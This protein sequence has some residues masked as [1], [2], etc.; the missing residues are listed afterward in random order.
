M[1]YVIIA[2]VLP[3]EVAV[4]TLLMFRREIR[5]W[6]AKRRYRRDSIPHH[7]C[8]CC[9]RCGGC[10][11]QLITFLIS[12]K[13][14]QVCKDRKTCQKTQAYQQMLSSMLWFA[15][16]AV[17]HDRLAQLVPVLLSRPLAA[18]AHREGGDESP[19]PVEDPS[20][21]VLCHPVATPFPFPAQ[22]PSITHVSHLLFERIHSMQDDC[23]P[24]W[25]AWV[26]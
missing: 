13:V 11:T 22:L 19:E 9:D 12:G 8:I 25:P 20:V 7:E 6:L 17:W 15:L 23:Q 3:L 2:V 14:V 24:L 26:I 16:D 21:S 5:H 18:R 1:I 10:A 4:G